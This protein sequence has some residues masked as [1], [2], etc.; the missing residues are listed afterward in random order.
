MYISNMQVGEYV[1]D[2]VLVVRW[3]PNRRV[4]ERRTE[5]YSSDSEDSLTMEYI[6]CLDR[7]GR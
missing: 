6:I 4:A 1:H 3:T 5:V 7:N 2:K